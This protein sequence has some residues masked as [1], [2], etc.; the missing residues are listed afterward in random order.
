VSSYRCTG[1]GRLLT[2]RECPVVDDPM[3][4]FGPERVCPSCGGLALPR[5]APWA[6]AVALAL[7][8]GLG[9]GLALRLSG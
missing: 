5:P 6:L 4:P 2:R 8:A 3:A 1:C 9:V 7:A